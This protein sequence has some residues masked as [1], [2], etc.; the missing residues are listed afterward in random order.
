MSK[1]EFP[2]ITMGDQALP[3]TVKRRA[4]YSGPGPA[5]RRAIHRPLA[6]Y[7]SVKVQR[8]HVTTIVQ[9]FFSSDIP[10]ASTANH[11]AYFASLHQLPNQPSFT[12]IYDQY[13]IIKWTINIIPTSFDAQFGSATSTTSCCLPPLVCVVDYDDAQPLTSEAE[14]LQYDSLR[15]GTKGKVF[16]YTIIPKVASEVL[17]NA[18]GTPAYTAKSYQ[19]VT[20]NLDVMHFGFKVH[21]PAVNPSVSNPSAVPAYRVM[22]R[23]VL[24]F[25]NVK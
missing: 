14:Y 3:R 18:G 11:K 1:F 22:H 16:R 13:R 8:D 4:S 2:A 19:W 5:Y 25:R 21:F 20:G 23:Y 7:K 15:F 12:A 9:Q 10:Y 6:L 24:Q 17:A